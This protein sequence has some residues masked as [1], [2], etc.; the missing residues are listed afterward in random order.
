MITERVVAGTPEGVVSIDD[1]K[2]DWTDSS[3][4]PL[5]GALI[6]AAHALWRCGI[7]DPEVHC[8]VA[9]DLGVT[10]AQLDDTRRFHAQ[11]VSATP[12]DEFRF[13]LGVTCRLTG[14]AALNQRLR[15]ALA[16]ANPALQFTDVHCL[17]QCGHGPN[18]RFGTQ[19][20]CAGSQEIVE[21]VRTWRGSG[22][23]P[24]PIDAADRSH[25]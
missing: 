20:L 21:D 9:A 16:T 12:A 25:A 24:Q 22:A 5:D 10:P 23:G 14:A 17:G 4:R 2:R 8:A 13:C 3:G 1:I 19:I 6:L 11:L 7:E 18:M 15:A